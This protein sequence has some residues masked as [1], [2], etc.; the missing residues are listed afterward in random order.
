MA[1]R[2]QMLLALA[3]VL[4]HLAG[5]DCK[6]PAATKQLNKDLPLTGQTLQ[7]IRSQV[8]AGLTQGWLTPRGEPGMAY[9]RLTKATPETQDFSIDSVHMDRPGPEH[10][11]PN[12]EINLCLALSGKPTFDGHPAGWVVMPPGSRHVPTVR[13]GDMVILYF[14]PRGAIKF[15]RG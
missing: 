6:D 1:D 9:G 10:T 13:D 8:V 2:E 11:H 12:G 3:P 15:H 14:L 5:V 4:R 7:A